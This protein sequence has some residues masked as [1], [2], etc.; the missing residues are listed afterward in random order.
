MAGSGRKFS[1][2]A[3]DGAA[4]L[5]SLEERGARISLPGILH[6]DTDRFPAPPWAELLL[7]QRPP[8]GSRPWILDQGSRFPT[9]RIAASATHATHATP[10]SPAS[11]ANSVTA[12]SHPMERGSIAPF[13]RIQA[14]LPYTPAGGEELLASALL[15][16]RSHREAGDILVVPHATKLSADEGPIVAIANARALVENP[17]T[18]AKAITQ[19]R[20]ALG[21]GSIVYAPGVGLPHEL[22]LLLYAGIDLVDSVAVLMAA[23]SGSYLTPEGPVAASGMEKDDLPCAC[24]ACA[25]GDLSRTGLIEHGL[26]AQRMELSRIRTAVREGRLR[27]LV[28]QR[29]RALPNLAAH[30][31]RFD[32]EAHPYFE[33]RAPLVREGRLFA[34]SK[35]SIYRP[36]IERWR[37]RLAERYTRPPSA[38]VLAL[39]PCS[40]RKPYSR[41]KTHRILETGLRRVA[42]RAAVHEVILTSPLGL[43]PRELES[44]Y[45]AAHYDLP[46]TGHW[47]DDERTMIRMALTSLLARNPYDAIIVHLEEVE[48]EIAAPV[49]GEFVWTC[50]GD[51]LSPKS[52]DELAAQLSASAARAPGVDPRRREWEDFASIA[53]WQFGEAG[54]LLL[55][56]AR[57]RGR[58]PFQKVWDAEGRQL[59][60]R[61]DRG[62]LALAP[63]G[64]RRLLELGAYAVEIDDFRPKGT[65]F[66]V[67]VKAADPRIRI[68]DE[69]VL[70]HKGDFRGVGRALLPG[71]AMVSPV[72]VGAVNLRHAAS[73][74]DA[75]GIQGRAEA[76]RDSEEPE[77]PEDADAEDEA[78]SLAVAPARRL[79][80]RATTGGA[81]AA[82]TAPEGRP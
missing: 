23:S 38:R 41:S 28:E 60:M 67:G 40:A 57:I 26:A 82:K 63:Q 64:G 39:L 77:E 44:I 17:Y 9:G 19:M 11:H 8:I 6:V 12:A 37:R 58:P 35:E 10:A 3:L 43:V 50:S 79:E 52:L 20:E 69:V 18:F 70:H 55:E 22:S 56:E 31:R 47:D 34:T 5:G 62:L 14:D 29:I 4:R 51:A 49:L 30:L 68:G 80:S 32:Y 13:A 33:E 48:M 27:E 7:A 76:R 1:I 81:E 78:S 59:A 65:V 36:E 21:F 54:V 53:T 15:E 25:R 24:P 71:P 16:N 46:V 2:D 75:A 72:R 74:A 61:T 45:P 66:S 42:N 73:E